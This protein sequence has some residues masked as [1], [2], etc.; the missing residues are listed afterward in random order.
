ME[1]PAI[2]CVRRLNQQRKRVV[3]P[4]LIARQDNKCHWCKTLMTPVKTARDGNPSKSS[5][6][7]DHVIPLCEGGRNSMTNLVAAHYLCNNERDT[8]RRKGIP[9]IPLPPD[10]RR[11]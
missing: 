2:I 8:C 9:F 4:R 10:V 11:K 5:A 6:T 1:A 7:I 3:M